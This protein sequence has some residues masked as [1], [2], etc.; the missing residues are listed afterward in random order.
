MVHFDSDM[1]F[2]LPKVLYS[3]NGL[4]PKDMSVSEIKKVSQDFHAQKSAVA[5]CYRYRIISRK[6]RSAFDENCLFIRDYPNIDFINRA[7]DVLKGEHDF[8]SF[9]SSKSSN[10]ATVCNVFYANPE[11]VIQ[12]RFATYIMQSVM[13]KVMKF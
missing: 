10:P 3:L 7:L 9:K 5:R 1:D 4:L 2:N 13:H 12:Q 11:R 6:Q 8:S